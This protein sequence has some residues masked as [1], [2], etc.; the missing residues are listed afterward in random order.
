M[1]QG[2]QRSGTSLGARLS[3]ALGLAADRQLLLHSSRDLMDAESLRVWARDALSGNRLVVVSNREPYSHRRGPG[4]V[5]M[6]RNPGGL[7]VALDA[8]LRATGGT[9]VA[10]GSGDA[11]E[12][13]SDKRGRLAVPE[14]GPAYTLAR[15]WLSEGDVRRYYAG[16]ANGALWPLSHLVFV[17]P[18]LDELDWESYRQVNRR[19]ARAALE[20]VGRDP[21]VVLLQ[22]YHLAMCA[23]YI[24]AERPDLRVA[25]F[26]H[27]PWPGPD[28]FR[29]LPW[30]EALLDGLLANDVLG[31]HLREHG[32]SFLET[33]A[34]ELEA[35]V[36]F[37]RMT[38][39]R[40]GH[41]TRIR[42][43]PIGTDVDGIARHSSGAACR[44]ATARWRERLGLGPGPVALGVDRLDY[45]KGI[46]ERFQALRRLLEKY[47]R[48]RGSLQFVQVGVPT[49]VELPEYRELTARVEALAQG[50]NRDFGSVGRP[51][52]HLIKHDLDFADV[53]ALYRLGNVAA[54][55]PLHDGM[56]LVAKE[57][58]AARPDLGGAL[59]LSRFTGA[60]REFR[61]AAL[62]NPYDTEA[63]ADAMDEVLS[64]PTSEARRRMA[65][66]R[67]RLLRNTIYDWAKD[68][69]DCVLRLDPQF[70]EGR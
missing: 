8:V 45:T 12:E 36:D 44:A 39:D 26:W 29:V 64:T 53:V 60:A 42:A 34:S 6:N 4:G 7:V 33:V 5:R 20:E 21:G 35:R 68:L 23:G 30:K 55:T 49:R 48:W 70:E 61:T 38:V 27:I 28:V 62:V 24:K 46:P 54:V 40:R 67:E 69:L 17:R 22:D 41:T 66:L 31:F 57:Y 59:V 51:F 47:P 10:H 19:F 52:L 2:V 56:N 13:Y 37:A 58:V 9:W 32:M 14:D 18:R 25:L 63:V 1:E 50:L 43:F 11:D 16:F 65:A 15:Q 3:D